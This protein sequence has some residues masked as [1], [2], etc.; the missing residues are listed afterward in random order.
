M[1]ADSSKIASI[2][3]H[4]EPLIGCRISRF[5][6]AQLLLFDGTW[7]DWPDLPIRLHATGER[8]VAISWSKFEDLW[9][10]NDESLPFRVD[11]ATVRWIVNGIEAL[12]PCLGH[13]IRSVL[14]GRG[15]MT[16]DG[17]DVEIWTRLVIAAGPHWIE[18]YNAL[19]ENGY[20]LHDDPPSGE[21]VVC[22][23]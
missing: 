15:A 17:S 18:L 21:F 23:S 4:F 13:E 19:D 12:T 7:T 22:I 16:W 20:T 9:L 8:L 2:R 5:E 6:T 10:A 1:P 3:A 11:D 14:L